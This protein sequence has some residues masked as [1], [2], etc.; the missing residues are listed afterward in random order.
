MIFFTPDLDRQEAEQR[1][2][3]PPS[4]FI[5]VKGLRVHYRDTG[6]KNAPALVLLHGFGSSLQ[7]WDEWA[8]VLEKNY[9]VIRLDLPGFGLTGAS[10]EH[11]YSDKAD[12]ERVEDFFKAIGVNQS[13][14]IGH[15]MGGKIAWNFASTYPEQVQR[16]ILI[17]PDGF[18]VPGQALGK[19]PY[20][21]GMIGDVIQF[22]MPRFLVKKSLEPAFFDSSKLSDALLNRY[23]DLLRAPTVRQAILQ[24]MRQTVTTDPVE[25]LKKINAPTL[26]LWGQE[27]Q[28]I[29]STNSND[30]A[31]V[32]SHCQT[33]VLTKAGHLLQEENPQIALKVVVEFLD[34]NKF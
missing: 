22:I 4:Q 20:D 3:Q 19:K 18:P 29:P 9:R 28:M 16:L 10:F 33:V 31:K 17:A 15:S 25:R 5:N 11:D 8:K 30:Y 23:Y 13:T 7:T 6:D 32:L 1:Y 24:R 2:A 34:A 21:V 14:V 27:D 12:V 26:L